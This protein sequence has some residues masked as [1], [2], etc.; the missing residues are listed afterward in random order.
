M[1]VGIMPSNFVR[2]IMRIIRNK[3]WSQS[4]KGKYMKKLMKAEKK[5]DDIFKQK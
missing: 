5:L 3:D 2:S 4:A 1:G